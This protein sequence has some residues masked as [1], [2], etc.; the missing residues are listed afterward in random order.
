[1][2]AYLKKKT[3]AQT[4]ASSRVVDITPSEPDESTREQ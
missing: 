4:T 2:S 3:E 1:M